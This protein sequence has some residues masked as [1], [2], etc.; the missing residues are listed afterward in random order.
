MPDTVTSDEA[1]IRPKLGSPSS[2]AMMEDR[3]TV[4]L[5]LPRSSSTSVFPAHDDLAANAVV[6]HE[7]TQPVPDTQELTSLRPV[8]SSPCLSSAK[9]DEPLPTPNIEQ[10]STIPCG[11]EQVL[12]VE[13]LLSEGQQYISVS[14]ADSQNQP[15][16]PYQ[17]PLSPDMCT[18]EFLS[19]KTH[20]LFS[21]R[22]VRSMIHG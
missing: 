21:A 17:D 4:S 22:Q 18:E 13:A 14:D 19:R 3:A 8:S 11:E 1:Q 20:R 2:T 5:D 12:V 9:E 7:K 15:D 6:Q 10:T 16:S